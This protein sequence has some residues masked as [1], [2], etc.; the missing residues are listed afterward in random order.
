MTT[1]QRRKPAAGRVRGAAAWVGAAAVYA[2]AQGLS[3][4]AARRMSGPDTRTQ[5]SGELERPAFAPPGAVFPVVWSAL[6]LA[7]ATSAW[8]VWRAAAGPGD[9]GSPEA[10]AAGGWAL[11]WWAAAIPVRSAYVPLEFGRRRLWLATADS[12]L[13]AAVMAGY[14]LRARRVDPAAAALAVP[15]VAWTMFATVLSAAVARRNS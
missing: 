3:A 2:S 14:T 9:G 5:Y 15:E 10:R 1:G 8:R 11:A 4:A 7:T 13:L 12:A 6:N